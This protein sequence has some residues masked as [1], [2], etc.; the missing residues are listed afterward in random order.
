MGVSG[1]VVGWADGFVGGR[2]VG[3]CDSVFGAEGRFVGITL[4]DGRVIG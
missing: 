4:C 1:W 3:V 2:G